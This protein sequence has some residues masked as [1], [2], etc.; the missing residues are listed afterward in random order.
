MPFIIDERIHSKSFKAV[1]KALQD[2]GKGPS[3]FPELILEILMEQNKKPK[4]ISPLGVQEVEQIK[5]T[6]K[7]YLFD[8]DREQFRVLYETHCSN[9]GGRFISKLQFKK[10]LIDLG[11]PVRPGTANVLTVYEVDKVDQIIKR[12]KS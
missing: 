7:D 8:S 10:V 3:Y 6:L 12:I 11:F 4:Q 9:L 5:S 1:K 2:R